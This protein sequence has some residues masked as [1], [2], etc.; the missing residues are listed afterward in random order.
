M[1]SLWGP[2][3]YAGI[4]A[5]ALSSA[6]AA[7][8]SAAKLIQAVKKSFFT[9]ASMLFRNLSIETNLTQRFYALNR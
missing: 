7:V 3:I 9:V 8:V 4:F 5:A 2:L 1:V 6:L